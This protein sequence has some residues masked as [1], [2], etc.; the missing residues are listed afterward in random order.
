[1]WQSKKVALNLFPTHR[2]NG[3][4]KIDKI[5]NG[6]HHEQLEKILLTIKFDYIH[7]IKEIHLKCTN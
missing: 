4:F 5:S 7:K 3:N 2:I 6:G 1:M